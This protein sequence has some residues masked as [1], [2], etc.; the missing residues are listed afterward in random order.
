MS[1]IDQ[2]MVL[3]HFIVSNDVERSRRFYTD[4]L[5][6]KT[7]ISSEGNDE[8]TYVASQQLDHQHRRRPNRRQA[9]R[10]ARDAAR[11]R[12]SEQL[13]Q[14]PGR[15]HP[16]GVHRVEQAGRPIPNTTQEARDRDTLLH[17]RSR[18]LPH[19]GRPNNPDQ[20]LAS[21]ILIT[22][23]VRARFIKGDP[24]ESATP[25]GGPFAS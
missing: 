1:T 7:V 23:P 13:P 5:G 2:E 3:A 25:R 11:P 16:N 15:G 14:H 12:S 19:R 8:V 17:P 24:P 21:T 6:G 10:H 18:R 22:P 9:D 4:I 20:R